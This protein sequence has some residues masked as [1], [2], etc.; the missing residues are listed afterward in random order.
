LFFELS[1]YPI[2]H[3]KIRVLMQQFPTLVIFGKVKRWFS[4]LW[5]VNAWWPSVSS[6]NWGCACVPCFLSATG[7]NCRSYLQPFLLGY[8]SSWVFYSHS[9][10]STH[11][12]Y[13]AAM[14]RVRVE[15]HAQ[16][17]VMSQWRMKMMMMLFT[18]TGKIS[19]AWITRN[20]TSTSLWTVT[21]QPAVLT[22]ESRS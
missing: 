15:S 14:F 7:C 22:L 8:S 19:V 1:F 20:L 9:H 17:L 2:D 13:Q 4:S 18:I 3:W 6:K 12:P 11:F 5:G 10:H 16:M 21:W